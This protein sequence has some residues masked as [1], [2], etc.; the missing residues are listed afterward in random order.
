LLQTPVPI[1]YWLKAIPIWKNAG[2]F[3]KPEAAFKQQL[4]NA[5]A[6]FYGVKIVLL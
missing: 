3:A 1:Y 6:L 5:A 2:D 4:M